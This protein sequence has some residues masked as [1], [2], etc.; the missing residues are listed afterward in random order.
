VR[1]RIEFSPEADDHVASLRARDRAMLL[2][3][4][5]RQL[6]YEPTRHTRHRKPLR[7]NPVAQYRL[8]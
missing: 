2:D 5:G 3:A 8:R 4:V 7:P 1:Y 6:L